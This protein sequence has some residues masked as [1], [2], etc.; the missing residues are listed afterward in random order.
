MNSAAAYILASSRARVRPLCKLI[1]RC[2]PD[3]AAAIAGAERL[4]EEELFLVFL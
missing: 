1:L 3:A 2:C 4:P